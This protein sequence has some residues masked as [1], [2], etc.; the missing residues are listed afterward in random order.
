MLN[1]KRLKVIILAIASLAI[2][3]VVFSSNLASAKDSASYFTRPALDDVN[4]H[5]RQSQS[6]VGE[7]TIRLA[8][9][10]Q[11]GENF[12]VDLCYT[13]PDQR[14]WL[15]ANRGDEV[16]LNMQG[17]VIYPIEEGTIDWIFSADGIKI[18]RCE[19]V[20]FP[21]VVDKEAAD[22]QLTVKQLSV[23]PSEVLDCPA[24]Q[25]ELNDSDA[26]IKISCHVGGGSS[27]IN[28]LTKPNTMT[29]V[30]ARETVYKAIVD[31]RPG[32]WVFDIKASV[33]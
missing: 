10:R 15:L 3:G 21:I 30:A 22:I 14:D 7:I 18:E 31:A 1:Q 23:S 28:I 19:Y 2:V 20:L 24:I 27:G 6:T 4:I 12:Q 8:G 13:L 33:P 32:P 11:A 9:F 26:G 16:M 25:K 29:E 17:K 5:G